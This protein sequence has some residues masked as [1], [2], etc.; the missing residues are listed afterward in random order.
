MRVRMTSSLLGEDGTDWLTG[1]THEA[2]VHYA[3][4]L[5]NRGAAYL[6]DATPL[7]TP[8]LS[9]QAFSDR[10]PASHHRD[11]MRKKA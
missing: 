1:E 10:D 2:T 9:T 5:V 7:P 11:P 8:A 3:R 6:V 4:Y